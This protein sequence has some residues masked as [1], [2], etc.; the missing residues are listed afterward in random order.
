VLTLVGSSGDDTATFDSDYD[1][2][3]FL[4]GGDDAHVTY[5]QVGSRGPDEMN[6]NTS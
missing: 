5:D 1:G 4:C 2:S 3:M 6:C